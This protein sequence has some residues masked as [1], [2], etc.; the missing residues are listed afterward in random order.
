MYNNRRKRET[1][2]C[3][4]VLWQKE[5]TGWTSNSSNRTTELTRTPFHYKM[6]KSYQMKIAIIKKKTLRESSR[7]LLG[8]QRLGGPN[9]R[10]LHQAGI[11]E[12]LHSRGKGDSEK[13]RDFCSTYNKE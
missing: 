5:G 6:W 2:G 13:R 12:G 4:A 8:A 3:V 7:D 11:P 9:L 10:P 1:D